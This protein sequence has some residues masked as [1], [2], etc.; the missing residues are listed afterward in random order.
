MAELLITGGSG[1]VGS[2]VIRQAPQGTFIQN[3]DITEGIDV[4]DPR[5]VEQA[6]VASSAPVLIHLAAFVD[7]SAAHRQWG[8]EEGLCYRLNV[9][10][11]RNVARACAASGKHLIHV[12]TD[13]V[14]DGESDQPY[15]E[16]STPHPIE[17]YG[18]TKHMAEEEV[19]A[20]GAGYTIV[21]IA[22]PYTGY[23][24]TKLD[25]VRTLF[26]RMKSGETVRA[27]DDQIITPTYLDD[28]V[29]GLLLLAREP[30]RGEIYHLVG[31]ESLTPYR[32]GLKI[33]QAF[34]LDP[35]L[36]EP[37]RLEDFLKVDPRPRQRSLRINN[38]KWW[39]FANAHGLKRPLRVDEALERMRAQLT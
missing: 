33:A 5:Q 35:C 2:A 39:S 9:L 36:V 16:Q 28:V 6:V 18:A 24:S 26:G 17:W 32:L 13:F 37:S 12:S 8:D 29:D 11:A 30:Q 23:P 27:F 38:D 19:I 10:G 4:T 34:A 22:F 25:L 3:I 7:V 15:D 14:F 20:S 31:S 21:R 1:F